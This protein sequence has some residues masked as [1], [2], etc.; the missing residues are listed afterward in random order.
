M[1]DD[2]FLYKNIPKIDLH[3]MNRYQAII[4]VKEFIIDNKKLHNHL[5]IIIHGKGEGILKY[6]IHNFLKHNK[7]VIAYKIDIYNDGETIV[8]I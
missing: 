4:L 2:Y 7:L 8:E 3:G 5:L 1:I 6:N